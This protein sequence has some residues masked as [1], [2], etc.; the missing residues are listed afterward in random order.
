MEKVKRYGLLIIGMGVIIIT[1]SFYGYQIMFTPNVGIRDSTVT[2]TIPKGAGFQQVKDSLFSHQLVS[3]PVSFG[4]IA[5]ILKYDQSIKHGHY[6]FDGLMSNLTAIRMLRAGNQQPVQVTFSTGRYVQD[7]AGPLTRNLELQP[8][9]L[10]AALVNPATPL[11]YGFTEETFLSM[12]IPNT[13][14]VYWTT[15]ADN[16]LDKLHAEYEKFWTPKR[17]EQAAAIGLTPIEVSVLAS[18]VQAEQLVH[19]EERP[20][21][22]GLYL[23]RLERGMKLESDPT[24]IRALGNYDINRVLNIH[25]QVDSPY[26]TYK[27]TGLPPGPILLP[28]I[29]AIEAVLNYKSSDY[30]FMCAKDD[31]SG[32]HNF[33]TNI[34]DHINNAQAYQRALNRARIF[35]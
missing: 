20:V 11:K 13:Y 29:N 26:N 35:R 31:L 1:F 17:K 21:I 9:V 16:L 32:Y 22:A 2:I 18:I 33:S 19:P 30:I 14:E 6:A 10:Q 25:K 15:T 34:R 27:Y 28:D 23:N 7:L 4:F 3:D 12:F 24:L 5:K 8:E